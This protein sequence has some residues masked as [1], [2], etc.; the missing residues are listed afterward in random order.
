MGIT[1]CGDTTISD[2]HLQR[3][4]P[5]NIYA[6]CVRN[7]SY[8]TP[9]CERNLRVDDGKLDIR[10]NILYDCKWMYHTSK[11]MR[12]CVWWISYINVLLIISTVT[13]IITTLMQKK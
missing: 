10:D 4:V 11:R 7:T 5:L 9:D 13:S 6:K 8:S 1:D 3:M 2:V 12:T